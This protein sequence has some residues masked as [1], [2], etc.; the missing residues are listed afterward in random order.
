MNDRRKKPVEGEHFTEKEHSDDEL[1]ERIRLGDEKA[2]ELLINRYYAAILRY[3][4]RYCRSLDKAEDLTTKNGWKKIALAK[5][6]TGLSFAVELFGILFAGC[7]ISQIFFMGTAGWD[8]PIQMIKPIAVAPLNMLQA[9]IYEYAFAFLGAIGFA[10]VVM[11]ISA[12]TKSNVLALLF[13]LAVVYGPM[14]IAEYL[15]YGAQKLL[16]LIPLTGSGADIFRTNTFHIF[17]KYIWS[18]YLLITVPVLIGILCLPF[19]VK[20]WSRRQR[21]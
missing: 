6:C 12:K 11:F 2:A 20:G 3:C 14:A 17:G 16:D 7:M 8:I 4:R 1:V 10:G 19:A 5:I 13:S 21:V 15:P 18:P 9:E